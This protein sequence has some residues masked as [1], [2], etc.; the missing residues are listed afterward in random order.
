VEFGK[1]IAA[2]IYIL[3]PDAIWIGGGGG[4]LDLFY[5]EETRAAILRLLFNTELRTELL[6]PALGESAGVFGA[7]MLG[8]E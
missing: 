7:A 1:A 2:V 3:D 4:N 6:R 8:A 5:A